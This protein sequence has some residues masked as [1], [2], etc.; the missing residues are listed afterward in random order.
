M[1]QITLVLALLLGVN[2]SYSQ[3]KSTAKKPLPKTSVVKK[4]VNRKKP[5]VNKVAKKPSFLVPYRDKNLWGFSD[6][7]GNVKVQPVYKKLVNLYYYND[8]KA[9]FVMKGDKNLVVVNQDGKLVLPE[10]VSANYDSISVHVYYPDH[11]HVHKN[12][13][14]GVYKNGREIF[15]P[16]YHGILPMPNGSFQVVENNLYGL[17]NSAGKLIIPVK[18]SSIDLLWNESTDDKIVWLATTASEEKKFTDVRIPEPYDAPYELAEK[19]LA[20]EEVIA[21]AS[22][23]ER[24][25]SQYDKITAEPDYGIYYVKRGDLMGVYDGIA[26]KEIIAPQYES[27]SLVS[28]ENSKNV[29]GVRQNGKLGMVRADNSVVVPIEFDKITPDRNLGGFVLIKDGKKGFYVRNTTY[30]Y[31]KPLYNEFIEKEQ[32]PVSRKWSFGLFKVKTDGGEGFVGENGVK[33]FR[34]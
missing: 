23:P 1:R 11:V 9:N 20:D 3:Q 12:G 21:D 28:V 30:P 27:I 13:K 26:D 2:F 10:T 19:R 5:V 24:I 15:P 6:T 7:L 34:D 25:Q 8:A 31:I 14:L 18:Y 16:I 22:I 33:F 4:T 32:I 17:Y 29:Y